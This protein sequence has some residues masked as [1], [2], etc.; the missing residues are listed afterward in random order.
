[1]LAPE[2]IQESQY[3][4]NTE[5]TPLQDVQNNTIINLSSCY[6]PQ[7]RKAGF[8]PRFCPYAPMRTKVQKRVLDIVEVLEVKSIKKNLTYYTPKRNS[9]EKRR[10]SPFKHT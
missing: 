9:R 1:M 8:I 3:T 4:H 7:R 5:K 6:T 2:N 10:F